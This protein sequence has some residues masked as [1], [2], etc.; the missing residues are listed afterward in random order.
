MRRELPPI[1]MLS[2]IDLVTEGILTIS[3]A[4]EY[5]KNC[6]CDLSRLPFDNNGAYLLA[7]E[8]LQAD[9]I[10]FLVGQ[11]INEFYQ[12][13]LLPKNISIRRSLIEDLVQFLRAKQREV[14][15][16]YC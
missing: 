11:S 3:K 6:H 7:K 14:T 13:P 8:M 1:G 5:I 2:C 4:T 15:I 12:N 10:L 16:E 9:S